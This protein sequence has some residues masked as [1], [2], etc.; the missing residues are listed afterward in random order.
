[1]KTIEQI[2]NLDKKIKELINK[3]LDSDWN[4]KIEYSSFPKAWCGCNVKGNIIWLD[5]YLF[6][7]CD[8]DTLITDILL[9]EIA[10]VIVGYDN[11]HGD[12]WHDCF[13]AIGG[14]GCACR[15]TNEEL[16]LKQFFADIMAKHLDSR[17]KFEISESNGKWVGFCDYT[18][19]IIRIEREFFY[20]ATIEQLIDL[21][22]HE[23]AHAIVGYAFHHGKKWKSL[24]ISIGGSGANGTVGFH[25]KNG[26]AVYNVQKK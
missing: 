26:M 5:G 8:N 14:N 10:H 7:N 17:W 22:L 18:D 21:L 9:H 13:I 11:G 19:H 15:S 4:F 16:F 25:D 3:H 1:M 6:T 12:E 20:F 23:I 2:N 24:Y